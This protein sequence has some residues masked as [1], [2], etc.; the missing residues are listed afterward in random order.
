M[1]KQRKSR[2]TLQSTPVF[3]VQKRERV[4]CLYLAQFG[5]IIHKPISAGWYNAVYKCATYK[6]YILHQANAMDIQAVS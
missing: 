5:F 4:K 2:L 1:N 6:N 3:V